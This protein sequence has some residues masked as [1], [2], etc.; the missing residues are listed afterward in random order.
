MNWKQLLKPEWRKIV[1]TV[2]IVLILGFLSPPIQYC[3][4]GGSSFPIFW[5]PFYFYTISHTD[6]FYSSCTENLMPA[7]LSV[8]YW[9]L[10]SCL[11]VWIYEKVKKK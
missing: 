3:A 10:L 1:I 4:G 7:Y 5:F 8:I 6:V 2:L 11:I 9:Y